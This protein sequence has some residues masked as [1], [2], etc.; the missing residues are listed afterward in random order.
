MLDIEYLFI[1]EKSIISSVKRKAFL[2]F[3]FP[4]IGQARLTNSFA[5]IK[6]VRTYNSDAPI[7]EQWQRARRDVQTD[8][9]HVTSF[10][11]DRF[12][13]YTKFVRVN[14]ATSHALEMLYGYDRISARDGFDGVVEKVVSDLWF[15]KS[16]NALAIKNRKNCIEQLLFDSFEKIIVH[17]NELRIL[18]IASG[19]A[20]VIVGALQNF[21]AQYPY[22]K[23]D[24]LLVDIDRSALHLAKK[25]FAQQL[26]MVN[27]KVQ[28]GNVFKLDRVDHIIRKFQ[29][30]LIEKAGFLDYI[31]N[32][33]APKILRQLRAYDP[34][35]FITCNIIPNIEQPLLH[36]VF[37]W[38][39]MVYRTPEIFKTVMVQGNFNNPEIYVEPHKIHV[40]GRYLQKGL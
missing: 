21:L 33:D 31:T 8:P 15:S 11:C 14:A 23:T 17:E 37:M 9:K 32:K 29:P 7:K 25:N 6:K 27:F 5:M 10:F 35:V 3:A 40:V 36:H 20:E 30:N 22:V 13:K 34:S 26:P 38:E 18:S 1:P 19:S 12:S 39:P 28:V 24:V 2:A 4:V 16:A